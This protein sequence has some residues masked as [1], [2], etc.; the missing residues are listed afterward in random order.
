MWHSFLALLTLIT[1]YGVRLLIGGGFILAWSPDPQE[2]AEVE[3]EPDFEVQ[4][5]DQKADADTEG[6]FEDK[7]AD[8]DRDR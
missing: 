3:V 6:N 7:K 5:E 1:Q 2:Q 8:L 4:C